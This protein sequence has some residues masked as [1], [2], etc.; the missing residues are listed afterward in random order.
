MKK[1]PNGE[2]NQGVIKSVISGLSAE[3]LQEVLL[4]RCRMSALSLG[5]EL[6]E[7]DVLELCGAPHARKGERWCHRGGGE[8]S[9]LILGGA[10]YGFIRPRVRTADGEVA[11]P[12]LAKLRDQDLL[13]REMADRML[14]GVSSR[15]YERVIDGYSEKLGVSKSAV[16]RAFVRASVKDLDSI[17]GADLSEH[18]FL[19]LM[20]DG[21]EVSGRTLIVALGITDEL[22]K[23]PLGIRDGDTENTE[24]VK[25]LLASLIE[26]HFTPRCHRVLAV[27]DGAKALTKALRAVFGER[28]LIQ[29]CWIHKLRNLKGYVPDRLHGTLH[30]RMKKLMSVK[31]FDDALR[32]LQSLGT[33]LAEV[34]CD[35]QS[36][37]EEV[38]HELL[39]LHM[40]GVAGDLRKSLSSTN[41]IESL[42]E[43]VR[44]KTRR[45]KRWSSQSTTQRLRWVAA[46]ILDHKKHKMRKLRGVSQS[47]LLIAALDAPVEFEQ[48]VA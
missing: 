18:R 40:L 13:D 43:R 12:T 26:R 3:A 41:P 25:D 33:W 39:T 10:R 9:S 16:S 42:L 27:I 35:A 14:R 38:G 46:A 48:K 1:K 17:N 5:T 28:V 6:L 30:W 21:I 11:L 23:I 37:L 15:N 22:E 24:L 45:V 44:D 20:V 8:A 4:E 32:E 19:A 36:S 31:S 29:R 34:S 47:S 7:Q 2:E